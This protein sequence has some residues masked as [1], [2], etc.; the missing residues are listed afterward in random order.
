MPT[1]DKTLTQ[2]NHLLMSCHDA[3][4]SYRRL[5]GRASTSEQQRLFNEREQQCSALID[6]LHTQILT[7]GGRPAQHLSLLGALRHGWRSFIVLLLPELG[8]TRIRTAL[9]NE[10][11]IR[12]G[13]EQVFAE[14]LS[15]RFRQQLLEHCSLSVDF[16][17][18]VRAKLET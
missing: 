16:E 17:S 5:A 7:Y 1:L 6:C 9:H 2:L 13:V 4:L 14:Q 12:H 15:P 10:Q 18:R 8:R 11:R 3:R